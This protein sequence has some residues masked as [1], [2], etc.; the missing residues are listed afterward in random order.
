MISGEEG[1]LLSYVTATI[2]AGLVVAFVAVLLATRVYDARTRRLK[3]MFDYIKR[4]R[5]PKP[6]LVNFDDDTEA[7]R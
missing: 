3:V 2:L 1:I 7:E 5:D 4:P 6:P